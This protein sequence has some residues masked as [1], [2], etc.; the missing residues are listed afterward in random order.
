M[1]ACRFALSAVLAIACTGPAPAPGARIAPGEGIGEVQLG[2]T[3]AAVRAQ[4]GEP[5]GVLVNDRIGFARFEGSL[6]VVLT[7]PEA[8]LLT[9]D[10]LVVGIGA[11]EGAEVEGP[12]FP[13]ASRAV[14]EA[15]LGAAPD[16]VE[17]LEYYPI[18]LSVEYDGDVVARVG[19]I[20]PYERRQ[21][22]PP[23]TGAGR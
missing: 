5:S 23:M 2:M 15:G 14:V 11:S 3:L 22:V 6:E 21:A 10:A 1:S 8:T 4:L 7:S 19:V 17:S 13:G 16:V 18:G 20:P 9:D 12:A